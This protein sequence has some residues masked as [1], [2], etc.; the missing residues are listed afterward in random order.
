MIYYQLSII[1]HQL[2]M[3]SETMSVP[4]NKTKGGKENPL[5]AYALGLYMYV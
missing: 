3:P 5:G 4:D 2:S 1:N